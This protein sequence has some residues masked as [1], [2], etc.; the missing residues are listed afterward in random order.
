MKHWLCKPAHPIPAPRT[1]AEADPSHAIAATRAAAAS[2]P[3]SVSMSDPI[4][5]VIFARRDQGDEN[6]S[7]RLRAQAGQSGY[8]RPATVGRRPHQV[9]PYGRTSGPNT[10]CRTL[11]RLEPEDFD[12]ACSTNGRMSSASPR[13]AG[14][15]TPFR[16]SH[17]GCLC[18]LDATEF[19]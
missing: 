2:V 6:S 7:E 3:T 15:T 9:S 17:N 16:P 18:W 10:K 13:L 1:T 11:R 8:G 4:R 12:E 14:T 5:A 19:M